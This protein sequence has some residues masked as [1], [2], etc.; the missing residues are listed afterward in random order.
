M[1]QITF[2]LNFIL[3]CSLTCASRFVI[4]ASCSDFCQSLPLY[5]HCAT[6]LAFQNISCACILYFQEMDATKATSKILIHISFLL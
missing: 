1:L 6:F 2:I 3:L 5:F 4:F